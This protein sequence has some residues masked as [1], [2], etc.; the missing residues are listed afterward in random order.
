[1]KAVVKSASFTVVGVVVLAAGVAYHRHYYPPVHDV[2][3]SGHVKA[4]GG[5]AGAPDQAV[6]GAMQVFDADGYGV[7]GADLDASGAYSVRLPPG[8]YRLS[9]ANTIGPLCPDQQVHLVKGRN[10]VVDVDCPRK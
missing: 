8:T 6:T 1:M 7:S 5:P 3:V 10:Q 2:T 4:V 9:F